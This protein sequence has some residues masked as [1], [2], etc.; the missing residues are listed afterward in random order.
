MLA[1]YRS[2]R[3]KEA[4]DAYREARGALVEELGVEPGPELQ[5][6][7]RGDPPP[8]PRRSP[9]RRGRARRR[10]R[11]PAP[12]TPLVGRRLEVAAVAGLLRATTSA[13]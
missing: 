7:E 6:L 2:G 4:L 10:S 12:P 3:Q 11:L 1:L 8:R 9:R 5:E 13:S